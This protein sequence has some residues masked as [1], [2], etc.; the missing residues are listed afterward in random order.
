MSDMAGTEA[1]VEQAGTGVE[2][3]AGGAPSQVEGAQQAQ[4]TEAQPDP[5][6]MQRLDQLG[7][8]LQGMATA[9]Q[10]SGQQQEQGDPFAEFGGE[11]FVTQLGEQAG[12][13]PQELMQ[14]FRQAAA[15]EAQKMV[16]PI[17][18]QLKNQAFVELEGRY[19]DMQDPTKAA[20]LLDTSERY[21]TE[22]AHSAGLPAQAVPALALSPAFVELVY[23][24]E[25]ADRHAAAQ[26]ASG[27]QQEVQLEGASAAGGGGN[28]PSRQERIVNAGGG[29]ATG[30]SWT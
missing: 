16:G 21:A 14:T 26:G 1:S 18:E 2:Q 11:E 30:F 6:V 28:E 13:D 10:Q 22:F 7:E 4:A 3:A 25:M 17:Q 5:R 23:K 19:P 8:T 24:A 29:P 20:A 12:V 9:F 15:A 27:E